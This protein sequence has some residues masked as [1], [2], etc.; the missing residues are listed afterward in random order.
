V[1]QDGVDVAMIFF[2]V[3]QNIFTKGTGQGK[4]R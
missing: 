3:N 1:G 2:S 4:S